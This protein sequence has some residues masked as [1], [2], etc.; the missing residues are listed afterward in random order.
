MINALHINGQNLVLSFL[1]YNIV[2]IIK[3]I[4][5]NIFIVKV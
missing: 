5:F 4:I 2:F 3:Y 1:E